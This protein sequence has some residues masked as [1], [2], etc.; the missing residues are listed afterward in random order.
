MDSHAA[1][2]VEQLRGRTAEL[3]SA[4]VERHA[5]RAP[6]V[7]QRYG[8]AGRAR[9][10]EDAEYHLRYLAEAVEAESAVL[11]AD[12]VNWARV[13]LEERNVGTE[14]LIVNLE[15]LRQTLDERLPSEQ[16]AV[17]SNAI[18]AGLA[19][20]S[21]AVVE[22]RSLLSDGTRALARDYLAA[23]LRADRAGALKLI[24]DAVA[25]GTPVRDVY[26]H[27]FQP[28][29]Y[30]IGRLWQV[31]EIS[32]AQ[33]HYCTAV[34]QLVMSQ[35]Y[36]HLLRGERNGWVMV[37]ACIGGDLH[38]IGSRMIADFFELDGWDSY[39]LGA[40][41]PVQGIVQQVQERGADLLALSATMTYHLPKLR[42]TIVAVRAAAAV[43][44]LVGGRPF[45]LDGKLWERVGAD[46]WAA[47]AEQAVLTGRQ[48]MTG[49]ARP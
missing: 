40:S 48:L 32:V 43:R 19:Q 21:H 7:L 26:L 46:G 41:T 24:L 49:G 38:E 25:G 27:V 33:E 2:A 47:D 29:Q 5:V 14:D 4:I 13:V 37:C 23:L 12:Y 42:E 6:D 45:L 17:F 22:K 31:N 39:F 10:L 36:P 9:C 28:V 16:A 1:A 35:L 3:A 44:V 20:L 8:A 18:E 15:C 30:E 11:F 34:T